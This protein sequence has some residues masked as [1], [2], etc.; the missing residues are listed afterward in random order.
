MDDGSTSA[1]LQEMRALYPWIEISSTPEDSRGHHRAVKDLW[2]L[3]KTPLVFH[4]EDDWRFDEDFLLRDLVEELGTHDQLVLQ[5]NSRAVGQLFNPTHV[6]IE[7]EREQMVRDLGYETHPKS[8][9]GWFWPGFSLNPSLFRLDRVRNLVPEIPSGPHFEFELALRLHQ[10]GFNARHRRFNLSHMGE[11]SAY[12]LNDASRPSDMSDL[13]QKIIARC[14]SDPRLVIQMWDYL[15]LEILDIQLGY[16][17]THAIA[18]AWWYLDREKGKEMLR[19]MWRKYQSTGYLFSLECAQLLDFYGETWENLVG[20][21]ETPEDL[22]MALSSPIADRVK[23]QNLKREH[24]HRTDF[25]APTSFPNVSSSPEI[26]LVTTTCRRLDLFVRTIN[27]FFECCT[28]LD[29]IGRWI[30]I[31]DNSSDDDRRQMQTALPFFEFV[32]KNL[33]EKG[34][35]KSLQIAQ[36]MVASPYIF[37]LE[38]DQELFVPSDY[39]TRC[40]RGLSIGA[41]IGQCLLNLNYA[42]SLDDYEIL[43]GLPF[44]QEGDAFVAHLFDPERK[45]VKGLSNCHWPHFSLRPG[46]VRASV[47][48][49]GFRNVPFFEREFAA[50]YTEAGWQTIFLPD[51]YHHHIGRQ[52]GTDGENAY[53]LNETQQFT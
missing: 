48:D 43:G 47:W 4:M 18:A 46:L 38:D 34:H 49:L 52:I 41:S 7:N 53:S 20:R 44:Q 6:F 37:H 22:E 26:T 28:D 13:A 15:D 17:A 36:D 10:K 50:R 3:V 9:N 45:L 11:V 39:V 27:S 21:V 33:N 5:N 24:I 23:L 19:E 42:E 32:W 29:R 2:Q 51:I 1:D 30:C 14:S 31:D 8:N 25:P 40:L 35:A 12:V 16:R